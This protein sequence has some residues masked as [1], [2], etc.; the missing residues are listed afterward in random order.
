[1]LQEFFEEDLTVAAV[2]E[3]HGAA[4]RLQY[5]N[6]ALLIPGLP[7]ERRQTL[8]VLLRLTP[9]RPGRRRIGQFTDIVRA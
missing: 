3:D 7:P 6:E 4:G 1:M 2:V 9:Q 5:R 8:H